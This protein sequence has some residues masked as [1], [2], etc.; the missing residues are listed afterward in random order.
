MNTSDQTTTGAGRTLVREL[1]VHE[2]QQQHHQNAGWKPLRE[3]MTNEMANKQG[4]LR[5][6]RP[7]H[8]L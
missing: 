7:E 4:P 6:R 8:I 3:P 2:Q 1:L 5:R